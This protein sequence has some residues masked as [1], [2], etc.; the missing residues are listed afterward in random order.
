[1]TKIKTTSKESLKRPSRINLGKRGARADLSTLDRAQKPPTALKG[2]N[3]KVKVLVLLYGLKTTIPWNKWPLDWSVIRLSQ[4]KF[5]FSFLVIS[6]N[7]FFCLIFLKLA[8]KPGVLTFFYSYVQIISTFTNVN[9]LC[10]LDYERMSL[11]SDRSMY[12][13]VF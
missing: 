2:L 4:L 6:W 10:N 13:Y 7:D 9:V 3:A 12:F 1:M 5:V 11:I 8:V